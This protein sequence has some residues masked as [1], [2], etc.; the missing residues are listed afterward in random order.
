MGNVDTTPL[1]M[2]HDYILSSMFGLISLFITFFSYASMI[3]HV[4]RM[5]E[6]SYD[7]NI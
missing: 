7:L 2:Y 4:E 1:A 6:E 3:S 5:S